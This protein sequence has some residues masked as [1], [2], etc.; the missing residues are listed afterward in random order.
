MNSVFDEIY[1]E[2]TDC[3][4]YYNISENEFNDEAKT[5]L[6]KNQDTY[7]VYANITDAFE[8][9]KFIAAISTK[10]HPEYL[11]Y[12]PSLKDANLTK[13]PEDSKKNL[14]WRNKQAD[15]LLNGIGDPENDYEKNL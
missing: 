15:L 9:D 14:E 1:V 5:Y 11:I 8:Q 3:K 13:I 7:H 4:R 6:C 12:Y 2:S 10:L